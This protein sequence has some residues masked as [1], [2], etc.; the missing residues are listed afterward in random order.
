MVSLDTVWQYGVHRHSVATWYAWTQCGSMVCME[1]GERL[2]KKDPQWAHGPWTLIG[3]M[4]SL[5]G[6]CCWMQ[7]I[8]LEIT[9]R[10]GN[11]GE[12]QAVK[13]SMC[14]LTGQWQRRSQGH[15]VVHTTWAQLEEGDP[16]TFRK[17]LLK[18]SRSKASCWLFFNPC[19]WAVLEFLKRRNQDVFFL[20]LELFLKDVSMFVMRGLN[21]RFQKTTTKCQHP[22]Q[23]SKQ[24]NKTK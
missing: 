19:L 21:W 6:G 3:W 12:K 17:V 4:S 22:P 7:T 15:T 16:V 10:S 2:G 1:M 11:Q 14:S 9:L 24:T 5:G 8:A 18:W 13:N 23:A 20:L